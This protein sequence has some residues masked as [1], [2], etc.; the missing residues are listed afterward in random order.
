MKNKK[1]DC[2]KRE[3]LGKNEIES[4][5]SF[6]T[7]VSNKNKLKIL[8]VLSLKERR[9]CEIYQYLELPQNLVSYH[10]KGLEKEGIILKEKRGVKVFYQL[11][12]EVFKKK[13]H[14]L[15]RFFK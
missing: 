12:K 1:L 4:L 6:L 15:N 3:C 14:S 8:C 5:E 10:L 13:M 11:N 9:V 7:T 2:C